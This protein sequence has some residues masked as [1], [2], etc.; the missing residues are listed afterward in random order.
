MHAFAFKFSTKYL[1]A[2]SFFKKLGILEIKLLEIV[3]VQFMQYQFFSQNLKMLH[4]LALKLLQTFR[5]QY[6]F[7]PQM[8]DLAVKF[9]NEENGG[10]TP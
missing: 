2:I 3:L 9:Y 7:S 8:H 4:G 6:N 5:K 1:G 10:K